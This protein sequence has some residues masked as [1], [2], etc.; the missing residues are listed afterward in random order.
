MK[1]D[2]LNI[3]QND[4]DPIIVLLSDH[5]PYLTK[6]C[7]LLKEY[8][9]S[10]IDKYDIQ[11]RY[12]AFLSIYWPDDISNDEQNIVVTQDILPAILSNITDNKKIFNDLKVERKFFDRF[13][14]IA[15]GVNVDNGIIKGGKDN[16]KPLFN[17]RTYKL[18]N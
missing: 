1:N 12:G 5:G 8:E 4:K 3:F 14:S 13:K 10:K 7:S 2:I 18:N 17:K 16:G 9:I 11:D 6:N 15:G